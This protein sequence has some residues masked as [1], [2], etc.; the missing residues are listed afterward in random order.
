MQKN[1]AIIYE[2]GD[3]YHIIQRSQQNKNAPYSAS[4]NVALTAS[5][6][7]DVDNISLGKN[8]LLALNSYG[9]VDPSHSP[10]ELKELRKQLCGWVVAKSYQSLLKNCRIVILLK[11]FKHNKIEI[12]PFDNCNYNKW[13][14]MMS[15]RIIYLPIDSGTEE[16]GDAINK[17]FLEATYHPE[18]KK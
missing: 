9:I 8:A 5:L 11:D 17:A 15:D 13:E 1:D 4:E 6:P 12:I 3:K 10:W 2:Y 16:V 18:R 7:L 14:S